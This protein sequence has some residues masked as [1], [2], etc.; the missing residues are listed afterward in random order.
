[1]AGMEVKGC[2]CTGRGNEKRG[3]TDEERSIEKIHKKGK[4]QEEKGRFESSIGRGIVAV[5]FAG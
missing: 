2:I 4:A 3:I 5:T 1:M